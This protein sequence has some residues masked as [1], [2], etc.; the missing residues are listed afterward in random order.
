M[1]I[2]Q[3]TRQTTF[4]NLIY[5]YAKDPNIN[6]IVDVGTWS[7]LGTTK[8]IIDGLIDS[9][10]TD[11]SL[12][13]IELYPNQYNI[14]KENLKPYLND[15]IKLLNGKLIDYEEAFWFDHNTIN[16]ADPHAQQW[17][18]SDMEFL[19]NQPNVF[20]ELPN[21]IDLLVLDGGEY[22]TYPEYKKLKDRT[23]I[24]ALDDTA[25]F[26]CEEIRKELL[27]D[28]HKIIYDNLHERHGCTIFEL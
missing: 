23:R 13:S 22:T 28:E 2:G 18:K 24:L 4:G 3:V 8:C 12:V 14:A 1:K 26:K 19:K 7:G 11:Y 9:G 16:M 6:T 10:K 27:Q 21:Q 17:Y 15:K 5:Q 20:S 25:V